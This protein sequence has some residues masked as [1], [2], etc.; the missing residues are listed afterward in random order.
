MSKLTAAESLD[1][2]LEPDIDLEFERVMNMSDEEVR[3]SLAARGHD[4]K[5]LEAQ[6]RTLFGLPRKRKMHAGFVAGS[7]ALATTVCTVVTV[8]LID[9]GPIIPIL[10]A[11]PGDIESAAPTGAAP[12]WTPARAPTP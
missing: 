1:M 2:A 8:S 4:L 5:V 7:L 3:S 9:F 11:H 10:A 12:P 6:A